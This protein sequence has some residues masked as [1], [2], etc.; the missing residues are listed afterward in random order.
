MLKIAII[1]ATGNVGREIIRLIDNASEHANSI[2]SRFVFDKKDELQ[3]ILVASMKSHGV[4]IKVFNNYLD[5]QD[6]DTFFSKTD[7]I[8]VLFSCASN[9]ISE[10]YVAKMTNRCG[11]II[12]KTEYFRDKVDLIIP[13]INGNI[14]KNL[15]QNSTAHFNTHDA[16]STATQILGKIENGIVSSPHD[17]ES[18]ATQILGKIENGIVSSPNC[19]AIPI[20]LALN[21]IKMYVKRIIISTYQSMSGG[22]LQN[23]E[24]FTEQTH[25]YLAFLDNYKN[26]LHTGNEIFPKTL[27]FNA[28]PHIGSMLEEGTTTEEQKI[29]KEVRKMLTLN[30]NIEICVTSVRIPTIIGHGMTIFLDLHN[31]PEAFTE[32]SLKNFIIQ[33][34]IQQKG[35]IVNQNN[36]YTTTIEAVNKENVF[37]GRIKTHSPGSISMW[38]TCDNIKKGAALN[39]LQIAEAYIDERFFKSHRK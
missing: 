7:Y 39:A 37:V 13:E 23:V 19:V 30:D 10:K 6:I 9:D 26:N 21:S 34:L 14:I 35:L 15:H 33:H 18:A 25:E 16:E 3:I 38:V 28:I 36:T 31:L 32:N 22:G 2:W 29:I 4:K 8:D 11:I 12:D 20:I 5:V 27:A 17:A 24:H 1:G